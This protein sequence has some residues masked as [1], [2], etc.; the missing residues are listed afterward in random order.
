MKPFIAALLF[1]LIFILTILYNQYIRL[2]EK[3]ERE[4]DLNN[5]LIEISKN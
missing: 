4:V 1:L 3:Y 2:K 5:L